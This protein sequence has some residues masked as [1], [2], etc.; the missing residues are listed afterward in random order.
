SP[1]QSPKFVEQVGLQAPFEQAV[2]PFGLVQP[3]PHVPQLVVVLTA[4]SQPSPASPSQSAEPARHV[5]A[6]LAL[7]DVA[8]PL[9]PGQALPHVSQLFGSLEVLPSLPLFA[10][11]SQSANPVE[12]VVVQAPFASQPGVWWFADVHAVHAVAAQP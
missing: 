6:L 10:L 2:A 12:H 7:L 11:P 3:W 1:S 8:C 9:G 4:V 5:K